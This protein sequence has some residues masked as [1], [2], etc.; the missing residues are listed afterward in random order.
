MQNVVMQGSVWSS[1]KCTTNMDKLNKMALLD[2]TLCYKY[3]G[4]SAISVGILGMVDDTLGVSNCGSDA[5]KKN[6]VI[7]SFVETQRQELSI[8][9][10]VVVHI[11]S[12]KKCTAPCPKLKVHSE[13]MEASDCTKYLGHFVSS[14]GGIYDT[15][16][17]RRK[18]GWGKIT[19]IMGGGGH[20]VQ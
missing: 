13:P 5:I 10:S 11:G 16:E 18:K 3:K 4:D 20:G 6:A 19:Q 8:E 2:E 15:V 1:L 17:D 12:D 7:N 9:K 14:K